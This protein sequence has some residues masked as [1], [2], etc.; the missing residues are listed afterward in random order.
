MINGIVVAAKVIMEYVCENVE[1]KKKV[2]MGIYHI[3]MNMWNY[4]L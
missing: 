1:R 3:Y 2:M 4:F